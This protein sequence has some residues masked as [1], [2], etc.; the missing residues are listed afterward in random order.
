[1]EA[2][3]DFVDEDIEFISDSQLID[4]L[5]N[6]AS[7]IQIAWDTMRQRGGGQIQPLIALRGEPNAGKSLLMNSLAEANA[8]IVADVP[9]TTRDVVR[10]KRPPRKALSVNSP[11]LAARAPAATALSTTPLNNGWLPIRCTSA[12]GCPV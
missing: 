3:L 6:I 11:G 12:E 2:G 8:A 4:R 9:G 7:Q 10:S 5:Q 1:M